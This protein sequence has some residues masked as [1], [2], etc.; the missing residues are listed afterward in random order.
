MKSVEN[1]MSNQCNF[2]YAPVDQPAVHCLVKKVQAKQGC[3]KE[4]RVHK[5]EQFHEIRAPSR[6]SVAKIE[7]RSPMTCPSRLRTKA[8][9]RRNRWTIRTTRPT[10]GNE[11][12]LKPASQVIHYTERYGSFGYQH[13]VKKA[14]QDRHFE[15][16]GRPDTRWWDQSASSLG[17]ERIRSSSSYFKESS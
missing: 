9:S 13:H 3:D 14:S 1:K 15:S 17:G 8:F 6:S 5:W 7:H 2:R 11:T 16:C 4:A 10:F 12:K